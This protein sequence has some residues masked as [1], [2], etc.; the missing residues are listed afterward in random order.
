[1]I[2]PRVFPVDCAFGE[3]VRRRMP[4]VG[5]NSSVSGYWLP[6]SGQAF[7][8]RC[9]WRGSV[10]SA[11]ILK[12]RNTL[13]LPATVSTELVSDPTVNGEANSARPNFSPAVTPGS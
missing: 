5:Q 9:Y 11:V 3:S 1:M 13:F 6:H 4:C 7:G 8:T 10:A 12:Y 2:G